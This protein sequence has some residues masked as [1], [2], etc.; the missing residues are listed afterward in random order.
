MSDRRERNS[1]VEY[2]LPKLD[3]WV[4]FP[5]LAPNLRSKFS[6][7]SHGK[8]R[9]AKFDPDPAPNLQRGV[10]G[11]GPKTS[12][13][14]FAVIFLLLTLTGCAT[15]TTPYEYDA[16]I[17]RP[18]GVYYYVK[19]GDTLWGISRLYD[20]DPNTLASTNN[21]S[22]SRSIQR[23]MRLLIP[24]RDKKSVV[25]KPYYTKVFFMWPLK[26]NVVSYYGSKMDMTKNKGIDIRANEGTGVKA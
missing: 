12:M 16:V 21:I 2:E 6:L 14:L 26:G 15:T 9:E 4:R 18:D 24:G 25:K 11:E 7:V 19:S 17:T 22:D 1:V 13:K 8:F 3:T 20:V 10:A 23:G 5:S